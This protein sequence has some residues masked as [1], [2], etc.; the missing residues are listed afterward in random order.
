M[1]V[2]GELLDQAWNS[3]IGFFQ[4]GGVTGIEILSI[5]LIFVVGVIGGRIISE[6][7]KRLLKMTSIDDIAVKSN[8]QQ[9]LR[10]MG[11]SGSISDL[12]ADLVRL[13]IYIL[14][15]FAIFNLLGM[16][17][18]I[19]HMQT[20]ISLLPRALLALLAIIIGFILSSYIESI[21]VKVFRSQPII[22]DIDK[23]EPKTPVYKILGTFVKW[24]GYT[25]S[26]LIA[27][28]ILGVNTAVMIMLIGILSLGL[29]AVFVISGKDLMKN[30]A[31]SIH[32]QLSDELQ[33]GDKINIGDKEG[34][35]TKITPLY[36]KIKDGQESY[37][38]PNEELLK[39]I[40]GH[41]REK[42]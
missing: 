19:R 13:F 21:I 14:V 35:I 10:K 5:A 36:T 20:I 41:R 40:I 29:V 23:T 22:R 11:Y 37:Y 25:A 12:I 16:Q 42:G 38:V 26:M 6:I 9:I 39:N 18:F 32:L 31:L 34:N 1:V 30:F 27:L 17:F 33:A 4:S 2:I 7:I 24:V 3:M 28:S 8:I 15:L